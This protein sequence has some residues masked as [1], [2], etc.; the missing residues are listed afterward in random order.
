M[1]S[2]LP[3]LA[4]A[5][6]GMRRSFLAE[7]EIWVGWK[8][9]LRNGR[10][11]E[12][13]YDPKTGRLASIYNPATWATHDEADGWAARNGAD[14]VGL[15]LTSVDDAIIGGINL[16]GCRDPETET[17]EP[18]A[19]AVIGRFETYT[20]T[21]PSLTGANLVFAFARANLPTGGG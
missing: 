2:D 14:G 5:R 12:V 17:I 19:Q 4:N 8:K 16:S 10:P 7:N 20:E 11:T 21:S 6:P 1:T 13:L 3:L 18:W 9:E 15:M